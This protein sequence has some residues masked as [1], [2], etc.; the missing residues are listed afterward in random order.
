MKLELTQRQAEVLRWAIYLTEAS[1]DGWSNEDKGADTVRDL[2]VLR[3]V[4]DKLN[5]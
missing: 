3:R 5:K 4:Y 1:F 2:A